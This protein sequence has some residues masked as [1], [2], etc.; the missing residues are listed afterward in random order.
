MDIFISLIGEWDMPLYHGPRTTKLQ[1]PHVGRAHTWKR[2][3]SET[4]ARRKKGGGG[5]SFTNLVLSGTRFSWA[6]MA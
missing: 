5:E 1:G 6:D 2:K 3:L 4:I